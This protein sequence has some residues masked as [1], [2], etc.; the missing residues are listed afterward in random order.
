MPRP[1]R[2]PRG[3]LAAAV[4]T[5]LIAALAG[6]VPGPTAQAT[7]GPLPNVENFEGSVPITT[8]NPGIF[9]FGSDTAS[10]PQLTVT[11]AADLP[12]ADAGNH[13]LDVPYTVGG[14]GGFSDD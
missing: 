13:A 14:Y 5:A 10:T 6:V 12:G 11:A 2:R 1:P 7:T 8:G 4:S 3:L 9:P